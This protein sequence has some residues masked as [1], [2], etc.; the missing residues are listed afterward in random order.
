MKFFQFLVLLILISSCKKEPSI[1]LFTSLP[2][3]ATGVQ[4]ENNLLFDKDFN[5]YTYRNFFNGGG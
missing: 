4:F 3:A 1:S 2:S 5:I